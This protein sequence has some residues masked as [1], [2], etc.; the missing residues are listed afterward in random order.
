MLW[1]ILAVM[2][3][4]AVLAALWPLAFRRTPAAGEASEVAFYRAQLAEIERDVERGQLPRD[5]AASARAEAGR[6]LIAA[7]AT[8]PDPSSKSDSLR[9]RRA[10]SALILI[11]LPAIALGFYSYFGRPDLPDAPLAERKADTS[12]PEALEAAIAKI[13]AHLASSPDDARGWAVLAPVY[14]RLGRFD[15]AVAAYRQLL[16]LKGESGELRAMYGEALVA[17]AGGVVNSDARVAFEKALADTP[18]LPMAR[19]YLALAAE[20]DGDTKGATQSY[21][22]LLPEAGGSAPWMIGLRARL[23]ALKGEPAQA[24]AAD[25]G[26]NG[27]PPA[28]AGGGFT[29]EQQEMIRGMVASSRRGSRK[30]AAAPKNGLASFAPIRCCTKPIEPRT[31]SPRRARRSPATR[32]R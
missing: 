6:R 30:T 28:R 16:R 1:L 17:A 32:P 12:S 29:P 20:Q 19:F 14:M 23:A 27:A 10:A 11:A 5:E 25:N 18:G 13:E 3:G 2:T 8:P 9:R 26:P 21:E 15:D 4:L 22:A 7:G 24:S 31:R